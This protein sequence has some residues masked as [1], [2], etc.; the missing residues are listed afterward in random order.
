VKT[1]NRKTANIAAAMVSDVGP[2]VAVVVVADEVVAAAVA[3]TD[4]SSTRDRC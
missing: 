2:A 4:R 1:H 3:A